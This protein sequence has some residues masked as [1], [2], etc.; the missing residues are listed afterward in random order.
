MSSSLMQNSINSK[1]YKNFF[2][3]S[4]PNILNYNNNKKSNQRP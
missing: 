3:I 2:F 4:Q 1:K